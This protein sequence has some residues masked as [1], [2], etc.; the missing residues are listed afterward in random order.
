M[1]TAVNQPAELESL[2]SKAWDVLVIGSGTA[3]CTAAATLVKDG[4]RTL[5]VDRSA[6]P[7]AKVCGG[8][9]SPIGANDLRACG[10]GEALSRSSPKPIDMI[11]IFTSGLSGCVPLPDYVVI[12]RYELDRNLIDEVQRIGGTFL[13]STSAKILPDDS[14]MISRGSETAVI[15]PGAVVVADGLHGTSLSGRREFDWIVQPGSHIG[16][17][18]TVDDDMFGAVND[19]I[20]MFTS[21]FGYLGLAPLAN[22]SSILA[23]ALSPDA[24]RRHGRDSVLGQI[25]ECGPLSSIALDSINWQGV[26]QLK[27]S[28]RQAAYGRVLVLGDAM[29]YIEP[30]TGE[31]MSWGIHCARRIGPHVRR[32]IDGE[33]AA[34]SWKGCCTRLLRRRHVTCRLVGA[35]IRRPGVLRP[36]LRIGG[37]RLFG[38]WL[39]RRIC[40][41]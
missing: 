13:Q 20:R 12:D 33:A 4:Y 26:S 1:V 32:I 41:N 6:F 24:I 18:A 38:N 19:R 31:G 22:G 37:S 36:L 30:F 40:W 25:L 17:G 11:E 15:S 14:V 23:A 29:R 35:A 34:A 21:K 8:C 3:G 27:R 7:R 10:L 2:A 16:I 9:L 28:R 5:V 39:S